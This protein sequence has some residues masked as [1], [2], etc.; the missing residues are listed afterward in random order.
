MGKNKKV[1]L[2]II[3]FLLKQFLN[4]L[5]KYLDFLNSLDFQ[6]FL[7]INNFLFL[8]LGLIIAI[9]ELKKLKMKIKTQNIINKKGGF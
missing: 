3:I 2:V 1:M 4:V 5:F 6:K 9:I 8:Q 7:L